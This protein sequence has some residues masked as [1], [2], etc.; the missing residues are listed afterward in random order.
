MTVCDGLLC[1]A[2][3]VSQTLTKCEPPPEAH[4]RRVIA[5]WQLP[6]ASKGSVLACYDVY[7][8]KRAELLRARDRIARALA[9]A[10]S[11]AEQ[12]LSASSDGSGASASAVMNDGSDSSGLAD[13]SS[14]EEL[15]AEMDS[16]LRKEHVLELTFQNTIYTHLERFDVARLCVLTYPYKHDIH[17]LVSVMKQS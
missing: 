5:A 17:K 1:R 9:A 13:A 8:S 11:V 10:T 3:P 14:Y 15:L 7:E 4:W 2:L 12:Q 6:A 16:N